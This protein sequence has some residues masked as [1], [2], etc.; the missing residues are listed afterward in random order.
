VKQK[1]NEPHRCHRCHEP[2]PDGFSFCTDC[3]RDIRR[4]AAKRA[5][6]SRKRRAITLAKPG[7]A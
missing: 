3:R 4:E 1:P 7:G 6:Q 2:I 5:T